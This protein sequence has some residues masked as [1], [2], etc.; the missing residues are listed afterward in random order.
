MRA[1]RFS[2]LVL[3]GSMTAIPVLAQNSHWGAPDDPTVKAILASEAIWASG[4]CGPQPQLEEFIADE[5]QGTGTNGSRYGKAQAVETD[6]KDLHRDCK[7]GEVKVRF[8]G[9]A[10]A[11]AYGAESN[12]R[13]G[14]D[15]KEEKRCLVWTDTWLKRG[16]KWQ[17]VAA[18]DN[19]VKC[20]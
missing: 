14:K 9:E 2:A 12:V 19:V 20:P 8:F 16:G 11:L 13:M 4:V 10:I 17:V 5:F 18:Q 1:S 6:M 3:I 15:G 7:L